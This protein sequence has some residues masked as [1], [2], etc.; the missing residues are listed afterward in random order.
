MASGAKRAKVVLYTAEEAVRLL[1]EDME[2]DSS[3]EG[4]SSGEES[5][6]DRQLLHFSDESR[7][8]TEIFDRVVASTS[9]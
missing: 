7:W 6:I 5:E 1:E 2:E 8:V 4:M 9:H 3:N